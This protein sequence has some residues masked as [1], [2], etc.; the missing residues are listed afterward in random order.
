MP[1][2]PK[3]YA[4]FILNENGSGVVKQ[5]DTWQEAKAAYAAEDAAGKAVYLYPQPMKSIGAGTAP[6]EAPAKT[7]VVFTA[8]QNVGQF[9]WPPHPPLPRPRVPGT[10]PNPF[11]PSPYEDWI[12][13]CKANPTHKE[14]SI[15][16]KDPFGKVLPY[17]CGLA[18]FTVTDDKGNDW[19]GSK[20]QEVFADGMGGTFLGQIDN[21]A[22]PYEA[23]CNKPDG[24]MEYTVTGADTPEIAIYSL[25]GPHTVTAIKRGLV[26]CRL[27]RTLDRH[28]GAGGTTKVR[29]E[30][31][32]IPNAAYADL[33]PPSY[34]DSVR[35]DN[36]EVLDQIPVIYPKMPTDPDDI[37]ETGLQLDEEKITIT[38]TGHLVTIGYKERDVFTNKFPMREPNEL[39]NIQY[40]DE[41]G[42][43]TGYWSV[44]SDGG[45][46]VYFEWTSTSEDN[47]RPPAGWAGIVG[48]DANG[49]FTGI[50]QP[51]PAV[52]PGVWYSEWRIE[53][54]IEG[55]IL[56]DD[57]QN[58][59]KSDGAGSYYVESKSTPECDPAG[60]LVNDMGD[61]PIFAN[62]GCGDWEV[63]RLYYSV[64]ADG[65]CSFYSVTTSDSYTPSGQLL[66]KCGDNCYFT[67]G[68]STPTSEPYLQADEQIG[69][70]TT[71]PL[72]Y[73]AGCGVWEIGTR[74]VATFS[75]GDCTTEERTTDTYNVGDIG[76]CNGYI[77]SVDSVGAITS[78][79]E[80]TCPTSGSEVSR[81]GN[82]DYMYDA[83]CG[84]LQIGY[85]QVVTANDGNCGTYTYNDYTCTPGDFTTCNGNIYTVDAEGNV[86]SRPDCEDPELHTG[87]SGWSYDGCNWSYSEPCPSSGT[88][89]GVDP[90]DSCNNVYADGTCGTYTSSNGSCDNNCDSS[91]TFQSQEGPYD[92]MYDAGCGSVQIGYY[93]N[94]TYADGSCGSYTSQENT[95]SPGDF[96]TCNGYI[97]SVDA[98]GNVSSR[99]EENNCPSSGSFDHSDEC[100]NYYADGNCGTYSESNGMCGGGCPSNGDYA[101]SDGCIDYYHNGECGYYSVDNCG[102]GCD[103]SGNQVNSSMD[104]IY[105]N[106]GCGDW[107]VG[108]VNWTEYTDGNCGTYKNYDSPTYNGPGS[109]LG[110]CN[111]WTYYTDG[112]GG[113]WAQ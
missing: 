52:Q 40:D 57:S 94:V 17:V 87:E 101:Y 1:T 14:C 100:N 73:D 70:A 37:E 27:Q 51:D 45:P 31:G 91:G 111:G 36:G 32:R 23:P 44:K 63:G 92:L 9:E 106:V 13:Y 35:M 62:V 83:G 16:G 93:Y 82:E 28:N 10:R 88:D 59:Y 20:P 103:S 89:L 96:T 68:T 102:N 98:S 95:S 39:H 48:R 22:S 41:A 2:K 30:E 84:S 79:E 76:S 29:D 90:N 55:T 11:E 6:I 67:S 113:A 104:S 24:Y 42:V 80:N 112:S 109:Y 105:T 72:T 69:D 5:F 25:N 66:G 86:T 4:V 65:N 7:P 8:A 74:S 60:T 54:R 49:D 21:D 77:Y 18:G 71:S 12:E 43:G 110:E 58:Y 19:P 34:G 61:E 75:R 97:Y 33:I 53:W 56:D 50:T 47:G 99:Q 46:S 85:Y 64:Y 38:Q 26:I 3:H 81:G 15:P 108:S 78:R 107:Y